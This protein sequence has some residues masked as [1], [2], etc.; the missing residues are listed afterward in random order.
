MAR[1]DR[2][3]D[4]DPDPAA[5]DLHEIFLSTYRAFGAYRRQLRAGDLSPEDREGLVSIL[6]VIEGEM[7][8]AASHGRRP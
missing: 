8:V 6:N 7:V 2:T 3:P 4:P 5:D 1:T